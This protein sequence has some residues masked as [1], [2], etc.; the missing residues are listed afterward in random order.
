MGALKTDFERR[1]SFT[2]KGAT[3]S[4]TKE[5]LELEYDLICDPTLCGNEKESCEEL[6]PGTQVFVFDGEAHKIVKREDQTDANFV[7]GIIVDVDKTKYV[8]QFV[9]LLQNG[10][11]TWASK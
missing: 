1:R 7:D 10:T 5:E 8:K 2:D 4:F 9:I 11:L 6:S 3:R